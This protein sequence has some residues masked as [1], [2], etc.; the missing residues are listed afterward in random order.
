MII[1]MHTNR[2]GEEEEEKSYLSKQ[3]REKTRKK[4]ICTGA[5]VCSCIS[6]HLRYFSLFW[7]CFNNPQHIELLWLD[8][9]FSF[10]LSGSFSCTEAVKPNVSKHTNE[11]STLHCSVNNIHNTNSILTDWLFLFSFLFLSL[12]L[13]HSLPQTIQFSI[14]KKYQCA[15]LRF[16]KVYGEEKEK[17][18]IV[19][20]C[21]LDSSNAVTEIDNL[22]LIWLSVVW[23]V[24][25]SLI[26]KGWQ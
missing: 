12:S 4:L 6:A 11:G 24:W 25:E 2:N 5:N 22:K 21:L 9:R 18:I 23:F 19:I 14:S 16:T 10:F 26:F 17:Q 13:S 1:R 20:V 7:F 15:F 8:A 3:H